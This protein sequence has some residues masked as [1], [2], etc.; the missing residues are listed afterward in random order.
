MRRNLVFALALILSICKVSAQEHKPTTTWPYVYSDFQQGQLKK[1]GG[2]VVDGFYNV[3]LAEGRLHFIEDG[4]IRE[5]APYEIFSVKIGPDFYAGVNGAVLKVLAQSDNGMVVQE[6]KAD[7]AAL[8]ATGGAYGSSSNS[9]STQALSS[10]EGIGGTRTNMNHMELKNSKDEGEILPVISKIYLLLPG[11]LVFA[12][13]KDVSE[14]EG[15]D[16]KALNVFIKENKI[17]WKDPQ[18]LI[19]LLDYVATSVE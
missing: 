14:I 2:A 16:K 1:I 3:H 9:I 8:N 18:S 11:N 12:A 7:F 4:M 6:V 15:I 19:V 13:K 5:A 10:L 17:K